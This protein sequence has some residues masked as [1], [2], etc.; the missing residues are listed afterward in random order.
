MRGRTIRGRTT[1]TKTYI[2]QRRWRPDALAHGEAE[3]VCLAGAVV[4][5]L[6]EDDDL[7]APERGVGP[8]VDVAC[9]E[10]RR[11]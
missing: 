8:G 5:V 9:F 11:S 6:A 2:P 3:S 7:D 1:R 4:G 10:G